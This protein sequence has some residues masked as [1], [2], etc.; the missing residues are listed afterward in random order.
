MCLGFLA[1]GT[2]TK[3]QRDERGEARSDDSERITER[4]MEIL[5]RE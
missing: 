4:E 3:G 2:V 5:Y 1:A